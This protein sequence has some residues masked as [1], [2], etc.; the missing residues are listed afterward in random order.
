MRGPRNRRREQQLLMA[1]I[2]RVLGPLP[3]RAWRLRTTHKTLIVFVVL[4]MIV[5][6]LGPIAFADDTPPDATPGLDPLSWT[7]AS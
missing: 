5:T 7:R 3:Q 2:T 4:G 1:R 6:I